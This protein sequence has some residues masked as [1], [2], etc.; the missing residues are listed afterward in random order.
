MF[1][2]SRFSTLLFIFISI[3]SFSAVLSAQTARI[4]GT[5]SREDGQ[6]LRGAN[7]QV[8]GTHQGVATDDGGGF[9]LTLIAPSPTTLRVTHLGYE[10]AET[11]VEF[12]T[13]GE[14]RVTVVLRESPVDLG[15]VTVT[16]TRSQ[17]LLRNVPLPLSI[18]DA[19]R[20]QRHT[21]VG[22]P[23][24]LEGEAGIALVRDGVWG[25]DVNIRGLGRSNVV[26]LVD[27]AR[28][29]TATANAAGLSMIDVSDVERIEVIRGAAS[30]LYGTGATGGVV[31]V[32]TGEGRF[33]DG[34]RMRGVLNSSFNSVND[35]SAGSLGLEAAND[36]WYLRL[37]GTLRSAT[38][39]ETPEGRLRDSRFHDRNISVSAGLRPHAQHELR[40][41]YQLFDARD[42]GIPG[43]ASFPPQASAR[44][45][46]ECREL[47]QA[48]YR[49]VQPGGALD[50]LLLRFSH[51]RID[52]NVE[53]IP[54]PVVTTRPSAEHYMNAAF[55]QGSWTAAPHHIVAGVDAWQ[56]EYD[57][58]R[59]RENRTTN[60]VIADLPLPNARFRS[61]GAFVQD[62]WSL[63]GDR[64]LL[65][66]GA[67]A[68]QVH[69]E[70][71]A[72][73]DLLYIESNG[74]RN[75]APANRKL[76]WS[77]AESDDVS[78]GAHAGLL[79]RVLPELDATL[80]IARSY[81]APSLEERFQYIELGGA[82]YLG[83]VA[84]A[85]EKGSVVDLGL[86]LHDPRFSL[87]GNLFVNA[88]S[89]LVVDERRS[90]T[91]YVKGNVGEALLYGGEL[92]AEWNPY[93]AFVVHAALSYVRGRDTG[94]DLDLP[95]IPPLSGRFGL[96]IPISGIATADLIVDA[97]AD[98]D[99]VAIGEKRTPGHALLH[100]HLRSNAWT[101]AGVSATLY[102]GVDNVFDRSWR[103][104]LSTLRGLVVAEPGRNMFVRLLLRF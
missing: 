12:T 74:K 72:G 64:L 9:C 1:R 3:I 47:M 61:I 23:D 44:Y 69:V 96:R 68:D 19:A 51:Q 92:T 79:Y 91:L 17:E 59:L 7:V 93:A 34:F 94:E 16:A 21:P 32:V 2:S 20:L 22:V 85:A 25:T 39:A 78:W 102:A 88:M 77:A 87:R 66:L 10:A 49:A 13:S 45:P 101:I 67:R 31:N 70:N 4:C 57:G 54:N 90:D 33:S 36:T 14:P 30:T 24:A 56:R 75:D 84:L 40:A 99:A 42:V 89:D 50:E 53:L 80:N 5:V 48:E 81:R 98:Q 71:E 65:T 43:G 55:L 8:V 60:T 95:Q 73:Y 97:T 29:E 100:F 41:R 104:H 6:P 28:I 37:R 15:A 63:P 62:E 18:T 11:P 38:D 27:G 86:R 26:T 76:L 82:T 58:R 52:R 46:D 83:D 103:R 35:G